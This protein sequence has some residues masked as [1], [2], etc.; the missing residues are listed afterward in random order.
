MSNCTVCGHQ[1]T[2]GSAF[3]DN[4]GTPTDSAQG[5]QPTAV[6]ASA[7]GPQQGYGPPPDQGSA[8]GYG[9]GAYGGGAYGGGGYAGGGYGGGYGSGGS[10]NGPGKGK[11]IL[12]WVALAVLVIA[13]SIIAVV[14]ATSG[15]D[16][17]DEAGGDDSSSTDTTEP[18]ETPTDLAEGEV[19]LGVQYEYTATRDE[20]YLEFEAERGQVVIIASEDGLDYSLYRPS[21]DYDAYDIY[22]DAW[23]SAGVFAYQVARS[24]TQEIEL[25]TTND[26]ALVYVDVV[27]PEE[28]DVDEELD[29]ADDKPFNAAIYDLDGI[30]EASEELLLPSCYS[31]FCQVSGEVIGIATD[32]GAAPQ[33]VETVAAAFEDGSTEADYTMPSGGGGINFTV[34]E[35]GY[36]LVGLEN[37]S[38]GSIDLRLR[39]LESDGTELCDR[40]AAISSSEEICVVDLEPGTYQAQATQYNDDAEATGPVVFNLR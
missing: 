27:D 13:G 29:L 10:S 7:L 19:A 40:D 17:D 38:G 11:W 36:V 37:G 18:V 22:T 33:E 30:F 16:S 15:G 8:G 32:D 4:C 25:E 9:P 3:C 1:I 39:V 26:T 31:D 5:D 2:A 34:E 20:I 6:G 23:S 24:G 14:L 21:V 12:V 28:L 35:A